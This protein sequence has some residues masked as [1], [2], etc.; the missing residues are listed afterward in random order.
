M[1]SEQLDDILDHSDDDDDLVQLGKYQ[2]CSINCIKIVA[3]MVNPSY[4]TP[5]YCD[6]TL[7][8]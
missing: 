5:C 8:F 3:S 1:V 7:L 6:Q 2:V 4:E